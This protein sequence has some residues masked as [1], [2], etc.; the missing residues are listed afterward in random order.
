MYYVMIVG[1]GLAGALLIF[2][3]AK[4]YTDRTGGDI[5]K[6]ERGFLLT[7]KDLAKS[8]DHQKSWKRQR[9]PFLLETNTQGI[10]VAGDGRAGAMNRVA[11]TVGE[12][13]IAI[14]FV[15]EYLAGF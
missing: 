7:G 1:T 5:L 11:S 12:G 9:E 10:M 14:K 3:E 8:E 2:I 15:H 13:V 4:P 6:N